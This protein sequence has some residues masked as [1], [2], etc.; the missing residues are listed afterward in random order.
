MNLQFQFAFKFIQSGQ[1]PAISP[2]LGPY[3]YAYLYF[4][5]EK[6]SCGGLIRFTII[7]T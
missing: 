7:I 3:N 4:L 5:F 2:T 6:T 1:N